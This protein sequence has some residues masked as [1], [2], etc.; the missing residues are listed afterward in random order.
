MPWPRRPLLADKKLEAKQEKKGPDEDPDRLPTNAIGSPL[1]HRILGW[2]AIEHGQFEEAATELA[3]AAA[4]NQ[5]D[6]WLRYYLSILKYRVAQ[7]KHVDIQGLPNMMIDLRAV[8]DW[9]P[10]MAGAYDLLAV[11]RNEGG[12]SVAAMQSERAA[13]GLSPRNERYVYHLA[14]IYVASKKWDAAQV[15]LERLKASSNPEIVALARELQERAGTERKYGI[16]VGT[17]S[18]SQQKLAPQKS[19]FDVL[20]EDAA[21]RAAAENGGES[22]TPDDSRSAKFV[23]GRLVI[24]DCSRAPSATLTVA[25]AGTT[26]KLYA[27]DYKSL[28]LIGADGFSCD[29]RDRQ[30]TVNYKPRGSSGGEVISLEMR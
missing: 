8:L 24:V 6:M 9:Y 25:A 23:K 27:P 21:K 17:A 3:D 10:E 11:A 20:E 19:P 18:A 22:A 28:V 14:Q 5:R 13:I 1:A 2:D 15:Q 7:S 12:S 30:V 16:P 26:L 29:W 4:L